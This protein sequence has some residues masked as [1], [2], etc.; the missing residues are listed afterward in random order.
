MVAICVGATI[1]PRCF[2]AG[3]KGFRRVGNLHKIINIHAGGSVR[4]LF[5][6]ILFYTLDRWGIF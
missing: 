2:N 6:G 3:K 1:D 5:S 4:Y